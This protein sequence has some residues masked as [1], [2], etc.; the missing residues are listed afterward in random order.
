ML[1]LA[2][3]SLLFLGQVWLTCPDVQDASRAK[4]IHSPSMGMHVLRSIVRKALAYDKSKRAFKSSE[5]AIRVQVFQDEDSES[6]AARHVQYQTEL[7]SSVAT[8]EENM[9]C[10]RL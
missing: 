1:S 2:T 4:D 9:C 6:Q 5:V 7:S 3:A 10:L 8:P